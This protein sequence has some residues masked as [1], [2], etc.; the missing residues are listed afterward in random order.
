M[1]LSAVGTVLKVYETKSKDGKT[2]PKVDV[3]VPEGKA[4]VM[5][6]GIPAESNGLKERVMSCV[7]KTVTVRFDQ[8]WNDRLRM[9]FNDLVQVEPTR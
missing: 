7:G 3:Y 9:M 1:V 5:V 2:Y 6:L 4:G 8:R